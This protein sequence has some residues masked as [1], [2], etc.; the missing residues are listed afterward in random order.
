MQRAKQLRDV[1]SQSVSPATGQLDNSK[2]INNLASGGFAQETIQA[3]KDDLE[4]KYKQAQTMNEQITGMTQ[5]A[6]MVGNVLFGLKNHAQDLFK[7]PESFVP[8]AVPSTP[9]TTTPTDAVLTADQ[10][11]DIAQQFMQKYKADANDPR[12]KQ[13][14][15]NTTMTQAQAANSGYNIPQTEQQ[16]NAVQGSQG[17]MPQHMG[18]YQAAYE[19]LAD[20]GF[21]DKILT[22]GQFALDPVTGVAK[23]NSLYDESGQYYKAA[24]AEADIALKH[25]DA[26]WKGSQTELNNVKGENLEAKTN[27]MLAGV[28]VNKQQQDRQDKLEHQFQQS[29][30]SIRGDMSLKNTET[31]RD[32]A[33]SAYNRIS[34]IEESG[35]LPNPVDYVDILGQIYK[36]RTGSAPTEKVLDEARQQT[37]FGSFGKAWTYFT[38]QQMPATTQNIVS[39]LKDMVNDMG[40]QADKLHDG[41]MKSHITPPTGLDSETADRLINEGRGLS[42]AEGT[43]EAR[44]TAGGGMPKVMND[45]DY[46][47]LPSGK[48]IKFMDPN[49]NIRTKP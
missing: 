48:K 22:P 31:Q 6:A 28:A 15:N 10:R 25:I 46:N 2:L 16:A 29:I 8:G 4:N 37:S 12:V 5:K 30:T 43:A 34:H 18:A 45:N 32:A 40:Q 9:I 33:I 23:L 7:N 13:F 21:Q 38:G 11:S 35:G 20:L 47:S 24:Q 41:Y 3:Q 49:G 36:A 14:L 19:R 17:V 26:Q 27:N 42:F 39:S 1:Y 44:K